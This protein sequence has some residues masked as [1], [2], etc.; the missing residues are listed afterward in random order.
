MYTC[1]TDNKQTFLLNAQL[2]WRH[3]HNENFEKDSKD[4]EMIR[5]TVV[6]LYKAR[7]KLI[8]TCVLFC[9][10]HLNFF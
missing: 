9:D 10:I 7:Q 6:V 3:A 5:N 8:S 4:D 1:C 2:F